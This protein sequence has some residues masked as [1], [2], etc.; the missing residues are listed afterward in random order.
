MID[1]AKE[2]NELYYLDTEKKETP[3]AYQIKGV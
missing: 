1:N 2:K 3:Q